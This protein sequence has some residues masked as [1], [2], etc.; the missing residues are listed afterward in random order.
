MN[1][2]VSRKEEEG[3]RIPRFAQDRATRA[4]HRAR[5]GLDQ[6]RVSTFAKGIGQPLLPAQ[7]S[8]LVGSRLCRQYRISSRLAAPRRAG[9]TRMRDTNTKRPTRSCWV[10][11][12]PSSAYESHPPRRGSELSHEGWPAVTAANSAI[13]QHQRIARHIVAQRPIFSAASLA[14]LYAAMTNPE[15]TRTRMASATWSP[16]GSATLRN[17]PKDRLPTTS[18][19]ASGLCHKKLSRKTARLINNKVICSNC[20]F[21]P[22]D[23][24]A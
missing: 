24:R 5:S 4:T 13:P 23:K 22:P 6:R 8:G 2:C 1:R 21:D 10:N 7:S 16:I 17:Y 15:A 20:M 19:P 18:F 9:I 12:Y 11:S 14:V 3:G